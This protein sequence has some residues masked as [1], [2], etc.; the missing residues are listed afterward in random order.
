MQPGP[1]SKPAALRFDKSGKL[2]DEK[3]NVIEL[4]A[5]ESTTLKI[6]QRKQAEK[7]EKKKAKEEK[8]TEK[9]VPEEDKSIVELDPTKNPY[10][11]ALFCL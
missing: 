11:L 10:K 8:H 9:V 6:N 3:G 4:A 2:L 5:R 1:S 7:E